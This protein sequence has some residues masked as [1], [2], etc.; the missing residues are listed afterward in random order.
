MLAIENVHDLEILRTAA[1][2]GSFSAA[3]RTLGITQP[4]VSQ[5]I[6]RL[7]RQTGVT[8][9]DRQASGRGD[10]LTDAGAV[11]LVHA[12]AVI[13][14]LWGALD[15][16]AELEGRRALRIGLPS[17]IAQRLFPD[18]L[19]ELAHA[20]KSHPTEIVLHDSQRLLNVLR[21]H[22]VDV[23]IV[24]SSDEGLA[25]PHVSFAKV[26]SFPVAVAVRQ[27]D[28]PERAT[29]SVSVLAERHVPVVAYSGDLTLRAAIADLLSRDGQQLNVVAES[30]QPEMLCQLVAAGLGVGLASQLAFDVIPD[31]LTLLKPSDD[32]LPRLNMFVFEDLSRG[33]EAERKALTAIKRH[34]FDAVRAYTAQ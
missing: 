2:E 18:N 1:D 10:F 4:A 19:S 14:E 34:L 30:D 28:Y 15:D 12:L 20:Q 22:Q 26:A 6:A 7:E 11:L 27:Q 9:F 32:R 33:S 23:G 17:P 3:A 31:G 5:A 16:L 13:D 24:T 25:L 29:I 8:L 21:I